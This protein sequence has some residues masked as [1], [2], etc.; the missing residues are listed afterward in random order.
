[1]PAKIEISYNLNWQKGKYLSQMI[2]V[3]QKN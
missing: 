2:L 1:M 3:A